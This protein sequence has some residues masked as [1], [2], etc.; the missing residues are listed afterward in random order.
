LATTSVRTVSRSRFFRGQAIF[1]ADGH[2]SINVFRAE[3]LKFASNDRLRG[4]P[5]DYRDVSLS[6]STSFGT[7]TVDAANKTITLQIVSASFPNFDSTTQLRRYTLSGD[8]LTW[9]V[10]PR[11]DGS[12]PVSSFTRVR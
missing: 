5:E 9:Q 6:M 10:P 7:Y 3:R 12:V 4:T 8:D 11:P 1:T 2:F